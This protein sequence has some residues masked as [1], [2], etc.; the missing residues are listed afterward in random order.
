MSADREKLVP[1]IGVEPTR[2][3]FVARA[4]NSLGPTV[5][6]VA[7]SGVEPLIYRL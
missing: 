1:S 3:A 5:Y 7:A 4:P 2:I 6:L